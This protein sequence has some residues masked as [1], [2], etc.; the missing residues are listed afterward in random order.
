MK[1]IL[2]ITLCMLCNFKAMAQVKFGFELNAYSSTFRNISSDSIVPWG[3]SGA[4]VTQSPAN[5][6]APALI[7]RK[8]VGKRF[9]L[10]TGLGYWSN[11]YKL[12]LQAYNRWYKATVDSTLNISLKYI[13][14]PV[15]VNYEIPMKGILSFVF[16][17]GINTKILI[18]QQDNYQDIIF[19][20]VG[21]GSFNKY[22]R[23]VLAP[24]ISFA[25]KWQFNNTNSLE[26]GVFATR[27]VTPFTGK[28][29]GFYQNLYPARILQTGIQLKYFL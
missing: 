22:K 25:G 18:H 26:L 15:L 20:K 9:S 8:D 14:V 7:L 21:L 2:F 13:Q 24:S 5:A 17:G 3:Y 1:R 12:N 27:D 29:W 23:V 11:K 4:K 28:H 10:E 19:E 6:L 16:T